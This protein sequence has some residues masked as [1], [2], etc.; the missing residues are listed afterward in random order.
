V[1]LSRLFYVCLIEKQSITPRFLQEFI[2]NANDIIAKKID[3]ERQ[4]II[5]ELEDVE[6]LF[7]DVD[8]KEE[9]IEE[10]LRSIVETDDETKNKISEEFKKT[11]GKFSINKKSHHH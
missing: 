7:E 6:G 5:K 4:K 3:P 9:E 1:T 10:R 11:F 2:D 8:D